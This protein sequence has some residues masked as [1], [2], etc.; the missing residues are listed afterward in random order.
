M[1]SAHAQI[2]S[3]PSNPRFMC[4]D[5]RFPPTYGV[6]GQYVRDINRGPDEYAGFNWRAVIWRYDGSL[7]PKVTE[8]RFI[9]L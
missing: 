6:I 3:M 8:R 4:Q 7:E 1:A 5:L 2:L 9:V